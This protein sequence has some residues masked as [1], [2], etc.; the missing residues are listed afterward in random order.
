MPIEERADRLV[1][2]YGRFPKEQLA[3]ATQ[4]IEKRLGPQHCKAALEALDAGD[5]RTVALITLRYYD[6][7]YLRGAE[8]RDPLR[9]V[10][11]PAS[12]HD[13]RG[14]AQRLKQHVPSTASH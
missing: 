10:K 4:R 5:L 12:A 14:L 8:Q 3:E 6:K 2:D 11:H 1:I 13:L 9:V 7:A